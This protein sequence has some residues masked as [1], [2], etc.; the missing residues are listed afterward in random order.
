MDIST[1]CKAAKAERNLLTTID[2]STDCHSMAA[3]WS[4]STMRAGTENSSARC[5]ARKR[6]ALSA[7]GKRDAQRIGI[8]HY[9]VVPRLI[10]TFPFGP[11]GWILYLF[12]RAAAQL[13]ENLIRAPRFIRC[14]RRLES[15]LCSIS[16]NP[17]T[18]SSRLPG[19]LAKAPVFVAALYC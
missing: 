8:A 18:A 1:K 5:A 7:A 10:L 11:A 13:V 2:N 16:K 4:S 12:R 19:R 6:R 17:S 14:K 15:A 3:A 9:L